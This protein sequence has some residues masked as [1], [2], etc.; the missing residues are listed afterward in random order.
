MSESIALQENSLKD[1]NI[2]DE[3][4]NGISNEE[5]LHNNNSENIVLDEQKNINQIETASLEENIDDKVFE[6]T[7][8]SETEV[9]I[10]NDHSLQEQPGSS[11]H[12]QKSNETSVRR[13]SLF[14]TLSDDNKSEDVVSER[15]VL[16]K[17]EPV[18]TSSYEK[19]EEN[20]SEN[21]NL[22]FNEKEEFSAEET[23][24]SE[25]DEEFNQETEEELLDIPTFLRRQAN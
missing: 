10:E 13:L 25:I 18:L 20:F 19:I 7:E 1:G 8:V 16:E 6:Q 14:D 12:N 11:L 17:T 4:I 15:E 2:L 24:T 22:S 9:Q 23:E 21:N 5:I 3:E